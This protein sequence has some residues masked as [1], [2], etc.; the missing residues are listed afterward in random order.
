MGSNNMDE[1]RRRRY[2]PAPRRSRSPPRRGRSPPRRKG[3]RRSDSSL[4]STDEE[5]LRKAS[6]IVGRSRTRS[7]HPWLRQL[8]GETQHKNQEVDETQFFWDGFQ[9]VSRSHTVGSNINEVIEANRRVRRVGISNLPLEFGISEKDIEEMLNQK[10]IEYELCKAGNTKPVQMVHID[11]DLPNSCVVDFASQEEAQRA[12]KLDGLKVLGRPLK[13]AKPEELAGMGALGSMIGV[14]AATVSALDSI[15]TSAKAA[16]AAAAAMQTFH[17]SAGPSGFNLE[18]AM[19]RAR[20]RVLKVFGFLN[21]RDLRKNDESEFM[22]IEKEMHDEFRK[23]G[24][25]L[26]C[27]MTK[28]SK[29]HFGA[30]PGSVFI[31]YSTEDMAE[32]ARL[33]MRGKKFDDKEIRVMP[34]PEDVFDKDLR[35]H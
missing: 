3:R 10:M 23:Y 7:P 9:W 13:V 30:E 21:P 2:R 5:Y 24:H 18:Q 16:A 8:A 22:S 6:W 14:N 15:D 34:V 25:I 31:Q 17:S 1:D 12:L 29:A 11:E 35:E 28:P 33:R 26:Y 19:S 27:R 32:T 20:S 4:S